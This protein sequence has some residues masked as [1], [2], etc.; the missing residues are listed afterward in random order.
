M[1][2]ALVSHI[3]EQ[4]IS[5]TNQQIVEN[6]RL[7]VGVDKQVE[8]LTTNFLAIQAVVEDAERPNWNFRKKIFSISFLFFTSPF[9]SLGMLVKK[10]SRLSRV[11][12]R[13]GIAKKIKLL[14][15][16]LD[17]IA[18]EKDRYFFNSI[19]APE[20]PERQ[21]TSSFLDISE[22]RGRDKD[23]ETL[24]R[25]LLSESGQGEQ[26]KNLP[27]ISIVGM[28]AYNDEEVKAHFDMRIWIRIAKALV[29]QVG[30]GRSLAEQ[31]AQSLDELKSILQNISKNIQG[32]KILFVLDDVKIV[33]ECKGLP[34]AAKTLGSL[35]RF[36]RTKAEWQTA[37]EGLFPPLLFSLYDLPSTI[38]WCFSFCAVFPKDYEIKTH[39]LI[40]L[41]MAQGQEY[42]ECL[43][44]HSLFQNFIKD[45]GGSIIQHEC[46]IMEINSEKDPSLHAFYKKARHLTLIRGTNA[47]MPV[48]NYDAVNPR[49]LL[50]LAEYIALP[51]LVDNLG[52][53]R[54]LDLNAA[55]IKEVP[56]Q[57]QNLMHLR[58]LNLYRLPQGMGKL[59]NLRH[60]EQEETSSLTELPIGIGKLS[61]LR[62]L[63]KFIVSGDD[64]NE[65]CDIEMLKK[66]KD[67]QGVLCLDGLGNIVSGVEAEKAELKHKE[68]LIG[69]RLD[70]F[71]QKI[72]EGVEDHV[73]DVIEVLQPNPNSESLHIL[74]LQGTSL[75]SWIMKLTN[76]RELMLRNC[77]KCENLPPL[78]N[79]PSLELLEIWYM[80]HIKTMG[81]RFLGMGTHDGIPNQDERLGFYGLTM[82]EDWYDWT[83]WKECSLIM[84]SLGC[85]T[86]EYYPKLKALPHLLQTAP[87]QEL[88]IIGCPQLEQRCHKEKGEDW[89]KISHIPRIKI[90]TR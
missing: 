63:T 86:I 33:S 40:K 27:I 39:V 22:I 79:L 47:Q 59:I 3:L 23:K 65:A 6:V 20:Q 85:L 9:V 90:H 55:A 44:A 67:L 69:L 57:V 75:P 74:Y 53:L 48:F 11:S 16:K 34:V 72:E 81:L 15:K 35:M 19:R 12:L 73:D 42:F 56:I 36:K 54:A 4:L 1:A 88:I 68:K 52:R 26:G 66:L 28:G 49:T 24:V 30:S 89:A 10:L 21:H 2:E 51:E 18:R 64:N 43:A 84:P 7:V 82:W 78:G 62:T 77:E 8:K 87:V 58:Y 13:H 17:G 46:V 70:F 5:I 37:E 61:S 25:K 41:W 83:S 80:Y 76:L 29:E 60:L 71:G 45:D 50:N 32:K 14:N 38:R 31:S